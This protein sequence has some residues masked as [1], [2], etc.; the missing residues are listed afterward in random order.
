MT[1]SIYPALVIGA[2]SVCGLIRG[3]LRYEK[4]I[5]TA[6]SDQRYER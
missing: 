3:Y 4:G 2:L 6:K 5:K 1:E